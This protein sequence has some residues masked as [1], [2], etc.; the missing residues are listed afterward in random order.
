MGQGDW[1]R[2]FDP[3]ESSGNVGILCVFPIFRTAQMGVKGP[4]K[5]AAPI[6]RCCLNEKAE[7]VPESLPQRG[8]EAYPPAVSITPC[9][10]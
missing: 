3:A 9:P 8:K 7:K 2:D 4:P 1:V 5:P 6:V 10:N